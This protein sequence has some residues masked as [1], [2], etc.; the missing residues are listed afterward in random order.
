MAAQ[1]KVPQSRK[2]GYFIRT[3]KCNASKNQNYIADLWQGKTCF[4]F[5]A[6]G[7]KSS[8]CKHSQDKAYYID[9]EK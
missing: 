6:P 7:L 1:T 2:L 5:S 8:Y 4:S 3:L 9:K